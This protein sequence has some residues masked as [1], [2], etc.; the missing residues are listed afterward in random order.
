M[1]EHIAPLAAVVVQ[2]V[3]DYWRWR[4]WFDGWASVHRSQ[5]EL[6]AHRVHRDEDEPNLVAVYLLASE[7]D[8][9]RA[10]L[11]DDEL[12]GAGVRSRPVITWIS[13]VAT[14]LDERPLPAVI[15]HQKVAHFERWRAAYQ[16][17]ADVGR[18]AGIT[19][20]A[21]HCN[22]ESADEVILYLQAESLPELRAFMSLPE[23]ELAMEEAGVIG[24]SA[25][26]YWTGHE[27]SACASR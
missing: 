11:N 17:F 26:S 10:L 13:P 25:V 16:T 18:A 19:G 5:G 3:T 24:G 9:L 12:R 22:A 4:R 27:Q 8:R 20:H 23:V 2:R 1:S 21:A 6:I 14:H 15:V 7:G